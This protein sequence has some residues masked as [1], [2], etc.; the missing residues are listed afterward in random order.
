MLLIA[1]LGITWILDGLEVT[2]VGS[3]GPILQ[4]PRTLRLTTEQIGGAASV[5]VVGAV[6]GALLFGW[7]TDRYGRKSIFNVTL[8]I[9]IVGV[10]LSAFSWDVR[11]FMLFRFVTG[12][13]IGGEYSA[14]NSA[15]D[16][17]IPARLRGR[18][19]L[20]VNGSFW[21]G[22]GAG[23][24]ASLFLLSGTLVGIDIGWRLGFGIGGVLGLLILLLRR[25]VPES[26]RWLVTHGRQDE[27]TAAINGIEREVARC[28]GRPLLA[29]SESLLIH[30][31]RVFGYKVVL[32]AMLGQY[33]MRSVL[34]LVMMVAQACLYNAV[35]FTYAHGADA[36]RPRQRRPAPASIILPLAA[37][38]FLGPLLL[39]HLCSTRSAAGKHDRR[40]PTAVVRRPPHPRRLAVRRRPPH[41]APRRPSA[42]A[43]IFFFASAAASAAYLTASEVFP[44]E[45]RALAIAIFYALGTAIGGIAAPSIFGALI[46]TGS[47]WVLFWGYAAASVFML[48]AAFVALK[49]GVD[50]EGKSL[51]DVAAPLSAED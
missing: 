24:G 40:R 11:S 47:P 21:I 31:R 41:R 45:M 43:A 32:R 50:A 5:Y 34:V 19:D 46:G 6:I 16:E 14:I 39:G 17:L 8:G 23:A 38:N 29:V 35:F 44:L 20:I 30:P 22:A 13:G 15:I 36:I 7:L 49:Y 18:V 28:T 12:I 26:P 4:D 37:G 1:A 9:Y 51:E 42:W 27:G 48:V 2:I 10:L 25:W 3:I 33:R